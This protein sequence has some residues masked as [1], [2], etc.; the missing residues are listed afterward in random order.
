LKN[1]N[2]AASVAVIVQRSDVAA[3]DFHDF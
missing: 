1:D 3:I 2:E